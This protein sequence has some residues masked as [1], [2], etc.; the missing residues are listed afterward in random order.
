MTPRGQRVAQSP[1]AMQAVVSQVAHSL[2]T[3]MAS[4]GQTRSQTPQATQLDAQ[5][6]RATAPGSWLEHKGRIVASRGASAM[7]PCGQAR[8]QRPQPTQTSRSTRATPLPPSSIA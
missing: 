6:A 3:W 7:T 2:T 4:A 8:T 1:Q 5:D